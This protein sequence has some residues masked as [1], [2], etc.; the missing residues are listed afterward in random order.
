MTE[1]RLKLYKF[2]AKNIQLHGRS[3][4]REQMRDYMQISMIAV[5]THI[6]RM[7]QEGVL[8]RDED[9]YQNLELTYIDEVKPNNDVIRETVRDLKNNIVNK[10]LMEPWV[11]TT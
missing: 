1:V 10:W 8:R 9:R 2:I 11:C 7:I 6:R 4:T 5:D 3:P